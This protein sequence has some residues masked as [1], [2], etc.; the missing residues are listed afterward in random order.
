MR[1]GSIMKRIK[2]Y[3]NIY[4]VTAFIGISMLLYLFSF[5]FITGNITQGSSA[6]IHKEELQ[7]ARE[8]YQN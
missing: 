4:F 5:I 8:K 3:M 2:K 7:K 1:K 6:D